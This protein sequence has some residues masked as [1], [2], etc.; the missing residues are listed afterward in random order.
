[1]NEHMRIYMQK[2]DASMVQSNKGGT[3]LIGKGELALIFSDG[4]D[5]IFGFDP[6][7]Q[8]VKITP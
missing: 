8:Q 7:S 3:T 1:M 6:K 5:F 4:K 2:L